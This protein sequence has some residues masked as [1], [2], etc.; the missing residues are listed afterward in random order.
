M[1]RLVRLVAVVAAASLA[2][3]AIA[4]PPPAAPDDK[5]G[6]TQ[7]FNGK[8]LT[9][10]KLPEKLDA[11]GGLQSYE[12]KKNAEGKVTA[13]VAK[14]VN[15]KDKSES[16]VTIWEVKDGVIAGGGPMTHLFTERDD[17]ADVHIRCEFKIS[18]KGN[19]GLFFRSGFRPGVPKGYEAQ[20][21]A[22]H[23]DKVKT[24]SIYPN[25]E[26]GLDKYPREQTCVMD[27]AAHGPDEWVVYEVIAKG[28]QLTTIVNGKKQ[29]DWT[30]PEHRFKKGHIA[31]QA[32]DPG[33]KM[34]FRKVEVKELK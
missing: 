14:M 10:W 11:G 25:G 12:A 3:P 28:P 17:M 24:G 1:F 20:I 30:D 7:L 21:N 15:K 26:F 33:S 5:D 32:H 8:D 2:I 31:L 4:A 9:G 18:D 19:S 27:K 34:W 29:V 16:D 6:W 13:Y 23:S 22:T